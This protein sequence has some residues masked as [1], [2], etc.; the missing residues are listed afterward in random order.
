MI[1]IADLNYYELLEVS[2]DADP[3]EIK[4][5]YRKMAEEYHPDK[6]MHLGKRLRELAELEMKRINKAKEVL[7]DPEKRK[8]YDEFLDGNRTTDLE[9]IV[10]EVDPFQGF[11]EASWEELK[12]EI[13]EVEPMDEQGEVAE[14]EVVSDE[15]TTSTEQLTG[16]YYYTPGAIPKPEKPPPSRLPF[17]KRVKDTVASYDRFRREQRSSRH[18]QD[19]SEKEWR[20]GYRRYEQDSRERAVPRPQ[21]QPEIKQEPVITPPPPAPPPPPPPPQRRRK[22]PS[23]RKRRPPRTD[24]IKINLIV[25]L[26]EDQVD[27]SDHGYEY[28]YGYV[29]ADKP[30][31]DDRE[32]RKKKVYEFKEMDPLQMEVVDEKQYVDVRKLRHKKYKSRLEGLE[33]RDDYELKW[34]KSKKGERY[35]RKRKMDELEEWER[36]RKRADEQREKRLGKIDGKMRDR[37]E[38]KKDDRGEEK[39]LVMEVL[40]MEPKET[41]KKKKKPEQKDEEY[42]E[43]M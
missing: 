17:W 30:E 34:T 15:E 42:D 2:R 10:M 26:D 28:D 36:H 20:E 8:R 39:P 24:D 1:L 21:P 31:Y 5:A 9:D 43:W 38:E 41:E 3:S 25:E 35:R 14:A 16:T 18:R 40:P 22:P 6:T 12:E 37:R 13:L 33:P 23:K 27:W 11:E 19:I 7:L 4:R 29:Y 32:E